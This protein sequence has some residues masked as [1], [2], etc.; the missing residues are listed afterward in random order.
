MGSGDRDYYRPTGFGG[1][2][3]PPMIKKLLI[4]N[5]IVFFI[6]LLLQNISIDGISGYNYFSTWF[7]LN[8]TGDRYNFQIW[9]LITYQF[10]HADFFHIAVNMF[11]LWMFGMEI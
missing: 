5:G 9:Q 4:I 10:M 1:L 11:I 8:P 7:A 3:F 2:N 6:Q